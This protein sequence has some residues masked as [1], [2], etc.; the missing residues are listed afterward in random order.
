MKIPLPGVIGQDAEKIG[1]RILKGI[2]NTNISLLDGTALNINISLGVV[3]SLRITVNMEIDILIEKAKE[4][5]SAI[6]RSGSN[7]VETVFI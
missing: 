4:L 1:E 6:K 3:A 7:Q 5:I 2:L